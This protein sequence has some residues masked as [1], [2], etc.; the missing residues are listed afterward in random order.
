M[1]N[2]FKQKTT[3][4]S[5]TTALHEKAEDNLRYIR[6]SMERA[7]S[8]TGV[9]GKGYVVAGVSALFATWIAEQQ[10]S[11]AAWLAVWML[12]LLFAG[13]MAFTLTA[14]KA[15]KQGGSLWSA[16]GK[17]L[18]FAFFP[19]MAVGA[20]F[21]LSFFLNGQLSVL[22]GV[23]LCLYGAAVMTA[24]AYSVEVIPI[25]G[26]LFLL[27]GAIVI[28]GAAPANLLLGLGLGGLHIVFGIIVWRNYGG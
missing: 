14:L 18:L 22:P 2:P 15:K 1:S 3:P 26:G 12:E 19:P 21:T 13:S 8:F 25:M 7:S 17:K 28:L 9:S 4:V 24:G 10:A 20:V 23:W 6:D 11:E 27:L 5:P 16:N